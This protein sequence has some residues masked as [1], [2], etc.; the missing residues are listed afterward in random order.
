M[1]EIRNR[2]G[3]IEVFLNGSF[4]FSAD[5]V[6]EAQREIERYENDEVMIHGC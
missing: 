2:N 3:H 5:T 4:V 6:G 1:Y